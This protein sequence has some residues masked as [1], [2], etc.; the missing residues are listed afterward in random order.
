MAMNSKHES[1]LLGITANIQW[2]LADLALLQDEM[3]RDEIDKEAQARILTPANYAG[4]ARAARL[5]FE[6]LRRAFENQQNQSL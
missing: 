3:A 2:V 5:A 6:Q 1:A 4:A